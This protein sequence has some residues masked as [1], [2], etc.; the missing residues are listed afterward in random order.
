MRHRRIVAFIVLLLLLVF[1][2]LSLNNQIAMSKKSS[3][4]KGFSRQATTAYKLHLIPGLDDAFSS[5]YITTGLNAVSNSSSLNPEPQP[6]SAQNHIVS[7]S[8]SKPSYTNTNDKS[9]TSSASS[10]NTPSPSPAI[11]QTTYNGAYNPLGGYFYEIRLCES[12]DNYYL[13]TGN[14]YYGAYQFSLST[15][16]SLGFSGLPSFA[17]PSLQDEAAQLLFQRSGWSAWPACSYRLGLQ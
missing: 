6:S 9:T 8:L 14:G 12:G 4:L 2:I 1:T 7:S 17:A 10:A 11:S 3:V 5:S 13:N 16:Y 15:W